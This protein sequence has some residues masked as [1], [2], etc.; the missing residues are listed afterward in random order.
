MIGVDFLDDADCVGDEYRIEKRDG[1]ISVFG[2]TAVAFNAAVGYLIRH[3]ETG[4]EENVAVTFASD[5]R[6]VYFANHFYNYYHAAP[7]DELCEYLES[8]AL[9]G[10]SALSLWFDMHHFKG[11]DDPDAKKMLD[12]M[13]CLFKKARHLGMKTSLT[14]LANEYYT[15]ASPELLAENRIHPKR[16]NKKLCG[17]YYTELCPS[18]LAGERLLLSSFEELMEYFAPV[19]IDYVMMWPYDQGGC[20]CQKCYPWGSNGFF[21]LAEK[22]AEIA[23]RYFPNV[24][25]IFSCWRFDAFTKGEWQS[26]IPRI[27]NEG[28]WID[29]LMVDINSEFPAELG[30]LNKPICSFPEISMYRAI[31]WGGFGANPFPLALQ[32]KFQSAGKG[33]RGG[34]LY[35]EGIFEDINKAV[36]LELMRDPL[37]DPRKTVL[38]YCSYHFGVEYAERLANVIL[39]LEETLRR[40]TYLASGERND[41]PSEKPIAFHRYVIENNGDVDGIAAEL[42]EIE[43]K[44]PLRIRES[45]RYQ[46]VRIRALGDAALL[47]NGG[48][49]SE[50]SDSIFSP[51]VDIYHAQNAYYFVAPVTRE[52]VMENRGEGV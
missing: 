47:E 45:W 10:Q 38:E 2:N 41:Y 6:A 33:C 3:Q 44:L 51:L 36:A 46:L 11:I 25:M 22:Q 43:K 49:P 7:V 1:K 16:Y 48:V 35:S 52:S 18:V 12:K 19:G 50:K 20:T 14:R 24:E 9:W 5:F 32:R 26:V 4:I 17:F 29:R 15:G 28:D 42:L 13:L 30:E 34:A 23:R 40:G 27:K 21:K 8:L 37:V 39:R 31:P